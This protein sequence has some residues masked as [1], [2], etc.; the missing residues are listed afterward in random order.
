M[1]QSGS[2]FKHRASVCSL[3]A[4]SVCSCECAR[5]SVCSCECAR[6]SVL[7]RVCARCSLRVCARASVLVRVCARCSL[8]VCARC[9][10]RVCA[11]CSLRVCARWLECRGPPV[12]LLF[13]CIW[14]HTLAHTAA[15]TFSFRG[16][17]TESEQERLCDRAQFQWPVVAQQIAVSV[18]SGCATN[19]SS[20]DQRLSNKSQ[21][22]W[23]LV[24]QQI[25][26]SV[27]SGCATNRSSSDQRLSNRRHLSYQRLRNRRHF[28]WWG[29]ARKKASK[30]VHMIL[31]VDTTDVTTAVY[32]YH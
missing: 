27:T 9:S 26:V 25:A 17:A 29:C 2:A 16:C 24:A 3:L 22:Q 30:S 11:R 20:S 7:V 15:C 1:C 19:R 10:L 32:L 21:F 5:A 14:R 13:D 6:A 31:P 12:N 4:A 23:L 18:T 28:W 8:R